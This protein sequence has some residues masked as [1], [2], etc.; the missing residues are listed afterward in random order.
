MAK[1]FSVVVNIGGRVAPSLA[2][3]I[4]QTESQVAALGRRVQAINTRTAAVI[5]SAAA[6]AAKVGEKI[7]ETGRS[8]TAAA[9]P[10]AL[11]GAGAAK[12]VYDFEKAGNALQAVTEM[13]REQRREIEKLARAQKFFTPQDAMKSALELGKTGFNADQIKGTLPGA[14]KLAL[15]GDVSAQ[16]GTD[17]VTNVMT[18]MKL[19]METAGQAAASMKRVGDVFAYVA[20]KTNTDVEKLGETFKFSGQMAATAG[21]DVETLAAAAGKMANEGIRGSE[22]G[23]ALRS[24]LVRMVRPTKPALAAMD[25]LGIRMGDFVKQSRSIDAAGVVKSLQA[26][27]INAS[28]ASK[29]IQKILDDP[30][31]KFDV[32]AT[33]TKITDAITKSMGA[34]GGAMDR[35]MLA[36]GI[37]D[38]LIGSADKIDFVGFLRAL[39]AKA[40]TPGDMAAIFQ[41]QHAGRMGAL[42]NGS[43]VEAIEDT[44]KNA[45]GYLDRAM[46]LRLQGIVGAVY[47]LNS[48]WSNLFV[49][50]GQTG[51][52]DTAANLFE[53]LA[54]GLD[55]LSASNP[56]LL[57][58]GTYLALSTLALGPFM[59]AAGAMIRV[60]GPL[61][62]GLLVLGAAATTGLAAQLVAVA[63]GVRAL[64]VALALGGLGKLRVMARGAN[65]PWRCRR[66]YGRP[67]GHCRQHRETR[68]CGSVVPADGPE[69]DRSRPRR[70][71]AKPRGALDRRHCYCVDGAWR[72]GR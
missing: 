21:L 62:R 53:R 12:S 66:L 49:T 10:M 47:R 9:A 28:G 26:Q 65:R 68:S 25:R 41:S 55:K 38:A 32:T 22:A 31:A 1:S 46:E 20:N 14:M 30:N 56:A 72:V 23:V 36:S 8:L 24:A 44:R 69:V 6:R 60:V 45:P 3:A 57:K 2:G 61:A 18:S 39:K 4:R 7:G 48:A 67:R 11:L 71:A 40:A 43:L 34:A 70:I 58:F 5:N 15:A 37:T 13:T 33:V 35:D 16:T 27:G 64:A 51:V 19:P 59:I 42:L 54:G 17:I 29:T 63:G 50:L 52:I